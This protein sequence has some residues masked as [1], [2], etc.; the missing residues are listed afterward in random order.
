MQGAAKEHMEGA[1]NTRMEDYINPLV[2]TVATNTVD[3]HHTV[4][5][6]AETC[7]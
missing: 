5:E 6:L 4:D 7:A 2:T 3:E 1:A